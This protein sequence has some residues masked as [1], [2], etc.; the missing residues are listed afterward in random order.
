MPPN[1]QMQLTSGSSLQLKPPG[2][3]SDRHLVMLQWGDYR[4]AVERFRAGGP[5][6]Y[7]AQRAT[8]EFVASLAA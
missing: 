8:V 7:I 1:R 5:E 3:R 2:L 4:E 6:T